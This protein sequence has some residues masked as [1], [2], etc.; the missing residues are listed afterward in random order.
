MWCR[1]VSMVNVSHSDLHNTISVLHLWEI[2]LK[3]QKSKQC[4]CTCVF[5]MAALVPVITDFYE[6]FSSAATPSVSQ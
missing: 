3:S 2:L 6:S 5:A 1:I 4:G